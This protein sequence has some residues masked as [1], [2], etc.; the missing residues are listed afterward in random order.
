MFGAG[1]GRQPFVG[2]VNASAVAVV[3]CAGQ[4]GGHRRDSRSDSGELEEVALVVLTQG[5]IRLLVSVTIFVSDGC[6][7]H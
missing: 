1:R 3:G 2:T 4:V 6:A 5:L 7:A